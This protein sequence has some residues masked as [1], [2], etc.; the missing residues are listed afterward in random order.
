MKKLLFAL[1][2]AGLM[3]T[4]VGK[5]YADLDDD[6]RRELKTVFKSANAVLS[7]AEFDVASDALLGVKVVGK[8]VVVGIYDCAAA[9]SIEDGVGTSLSPNIRTEAEAFYDN[10]MNIGDTPFPFRMTFDAGL[11][12]SFNSEDIARADAPYGVFLYI[13][14]DYNKYN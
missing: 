4:A 10:Q 5:A 9:T 7:T 6:P 13:E 11:T 2:I 8:A 12:V 14:E 3:F 1:L